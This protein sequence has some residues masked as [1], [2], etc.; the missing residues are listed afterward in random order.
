M[1]KLLNYNH[2]YYKQLFE[3]YGF[4]NYYN[5]I[6]FGLDPHKKVNDKIIERHAHLAENPAFKAR[7]IKKNQLE[8]FAGDFTIVYNKAWAGHGGIKEFKKEQVINIFKSMKPVM[9]E[10]IAWFVYHHE[11][12]IAIFINIPDLN[13]WFKYLNGK[14]DFWHKLKFLWIKKNKP[15]KKFTGIVFGIVPEFQGKGVDAYMIYEAANIIQPLNQYDDYEMQ[16]IGDFNPKM[17]SI[18]ENLGTQKT[19]ILK[20]YRYLFDRTKEFK[21]HPIL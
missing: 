19:R 5:Q 7:H 13:Q 3:T 9:D 20:T 1:L 10:R 17:V 4:K 21:R 8:K 14:F 6:C 16:W 15:N 11:A 2:S 18:A 12:P